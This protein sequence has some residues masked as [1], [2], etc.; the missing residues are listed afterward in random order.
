MTQRGN[1]RQSPA[2]S[3]SCGGRAES[4]KPRQLGFREQTNYVIAAQRENSGVLEGKE[5]SLSTQLSTGQYMI[6]ARK[7][8]ETRTALERSQCYSAWHS[9]KM[10]TVPVPISHFSA[11]S[12]IHRRVL[13]EC[14]KI[15]SLR[16]NSG[17]V[18]P[19]RP[20]KI[21]V[22]PGNSTTSQNKAQEY[23]KQYNTVQHPTR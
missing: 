20:K 21:K 14:W 19:N 5:S 16:L 11:L 3:L 15:F 10:R 17:T 12:R 1:P 2:D 8:H 6:C 18:P 4:P 13:P 23:S 22:S 9:R 7:L